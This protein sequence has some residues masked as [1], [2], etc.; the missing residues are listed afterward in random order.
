MRASAKRA[1]G[2]ALAA[3]LPAAVVACRGLLAIDDKTLVDGGAES[4]ADGGADGAPRD[5]AEADG[6]AGCGVGACVNGACE[7]T[8]LATTSGDVRRLYVEGDG[9]VWLDGASGEIRR[10]AA[11]GGAS[12]VLQTPGPGAAGVF[13]KGVFLFWTTA[14]GDVVRQNTN[15]GSS[16]F[17]MATGETGAAHVFASGA[18]AFFTV[19]ATAGAL[20]RVG[21]DGGAVSTVADVSSPTS[22]ASLTDDSSAPLFYLA[23]GAGA[24]LYSSPRAGAGK[25]RLFGGAVAGL[26]IDA[27]SVFTGDVAGRRLLSFTFDGSREGVLAEGV[28]VVDLATAPD[29][30]EVVWA[31]A[32]GT[33][34]GV[35]KAGRAARTIAGAAERPGPI[36]T[37]GTIVVW[38]AGRGLY[39]AT[40]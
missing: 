32:N 40:L 25:T 27:T 34:R 24:G 21:Y 14:A 5:G 31:D 30:G 8:L 6:C 22:L 13:R 20:R 33:I 36:A 18:S 7:G 15:D 26:A 2:L 10:V 9:V 28:D 29:Y 19:S 38:A 1:P 3:L 4:P 12:H 39:I 17:V 16:P 37:D 23:G 11:A 35:K